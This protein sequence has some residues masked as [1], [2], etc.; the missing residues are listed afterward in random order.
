MT[1][2]EVFMVNPEQVNAKPNSIEVKTTPYS[3]FVAILVLITYAISFICRNVWSTAIPIAYESLG[4]TMAAAGGLMTAFYIGYCASQIFISSV[5][6][7]L[8]GRRSIALSVAL[9]GLFTLLIPFVPGGYWAMF[10]LRLLAGFVSGP[11][12]AG[13]IKYQLS[14]FG[15]ATRTTAFGLMTCGPPLGTA[16]SGLAMGP[17]IAKSWELGFVVAAVA[18]LIISVVFYAFAKDKTG[19]A[20]DPAV[21]K[22]PKINAADRRAI[23]AIVTKKS[24]VF[25]TVAYF[26]A[27][28]QG[29]GFNTYIISYFTIVRGFTLEAA[30]LLFGGTAMVGMVAGVVAGG[31]ADL[32]RN[33]KLCCYL[34]SAVSVVCTVLLMTVSGIGGLTVILLVRTLFGAFMSNPLGALLAENAE[35]P[36]AGGAMG[37]YSGFAQ[38]GAILFPLLFG[39]ILDM[40]G[41]DYSIMIITITAACGLCGVLIAFVEEK[42]LARKESAAG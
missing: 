13:V 36:H 28:G 34:G 39:V 5:V 25:G 14:Y 7:K 26:L 10:A 9:T 3:W 27:I 12:F 41:N 22:A 8:G 24:F 35:G 38:T 40:T 6:D 4:F 18:T 16:L 37:I 32:L 2:E 29:V 19:S 42:R 31:T 30:A 15:H 33:K 1:V 21:S 20:P 23:L 17:V 11:I